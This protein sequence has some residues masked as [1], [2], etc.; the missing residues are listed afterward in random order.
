MSSSQQS[1]RRDLALIVIT[2]VIAVA[3]TAFAV[4]AAWFIF[5][6]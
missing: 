2:A 5:G 3:A 6:S 4:G 1:Q